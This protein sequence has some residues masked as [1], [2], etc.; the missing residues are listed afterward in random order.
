MKPLSPLL[1]VKNNFKNVLPIFISMIIGV[2]LIYFFSLFSATTTKMLHVA[3][4]NIMEQYNVSYITKD[5]TLP[6]DFR[7][8]IMSTQEVLPVRM[9]LSGL[10]YFRG[11]LGNTTILTFNM[12][13][14]DVPRLLDSLGLRVEEGNLPR[15]NQNEIAVPVEYA[16]QNNLKVGD[17]IGTAISEEYGLQ[18]KYTICGLTK[19]D[20]LFSV[21]CQP[22]DMSREEVAEQGIMYQLDKLGDINIKQLVEKLPDNVLTLSHDYYDNAY[23]V[24]ISSMNALTYV[25]TFVMMVVLCIALGNLNIVVYDNRRDELKILHS[26]GITT[27]KLVQKLWLENLL[28]CVAGYLSG[29]LLTI[30]IVCIYN[31]A[32]LYPTGKAMEMI[33]GQGLIVALTLPVFVSIFSLVP[34]LLGYR[35]EENLL[36]EG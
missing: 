19:G 23:S 11:G 29:V 7:E 25:F 9:N 6:D 32:L 27:K 33:Y 4:F 14:E 5:G 21:S 18:G 2:F 20:V 15:N 26:I 34:S 10:P 17:A 3:S 1:Y 24:T 16:L 13:E 31:N 22:G 36:V 12:F 30:I 8:Q 35:N 28:V